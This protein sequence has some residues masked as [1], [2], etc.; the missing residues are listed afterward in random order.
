MQARLNAMEIS[1]SGHWMATGSYP[2][3][4][5]PP[6]TKRGCTRYCRGFTLIEITIALVILS[7][8][9]ATVYLALDGAITSVERV[10]EAQEP[11][12]KA[13]VARSFLTSSLRS[14][15]AFTGLQG[16]GFVAVDSAYGG[17]P[18]DELTFVALT[19]SGADSP[20]MQVHLFVADSAGTPNLRL[21][22]RPL[23][24]RDS[25]PPYQS[26][27]L[28]TGVA[29]LDIH[30]LAAPSADR[31]SWQERWDSQIRLPYAVRISFILSETPDPLYRVPIVIQIPAGRII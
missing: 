25:L 8:I 17:T 19:P 20:R 31:S 1:D 30:Y 26:Y 15:A 4:A 5:T 3:G 7:L 13:R 29:G 12:Q 9:T 24:V 16:D 18:M 27:T 6:G 14:A 11:Y 28:S 10:K 2:A 21:E 22:V 23:G